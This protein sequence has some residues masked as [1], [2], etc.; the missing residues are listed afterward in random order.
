[1]ATQ[2]CR[3]PTALVVIDVQVAWS[4]SSR[5][6]PRHIAEDESVLAKINTC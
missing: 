4:M 3:H 6:I 2:T 1:M 5:M